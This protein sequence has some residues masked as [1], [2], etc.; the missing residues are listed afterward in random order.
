MKDLIYN[1]PDVFYAINVL[2]ACGVAL[3]FMLIV[4]NSFRD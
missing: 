2:I 4:T 3:L 1:L